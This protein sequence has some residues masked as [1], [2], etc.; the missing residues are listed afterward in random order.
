[1]NTWTIVVLILVFHFVISIEILL[2]AAPL[3][4]AV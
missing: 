2:D 1:M 3:Q 4:V